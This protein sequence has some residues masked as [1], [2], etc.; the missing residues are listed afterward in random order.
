LLALSCTS[1]FM[2]LALGSIDVG[3]RPFRAGGY[4]G[5]FVAGL[6]AEYLSRMGS[7]IVI[8]ALLLVAVILTTQFSFGRLFSVIFAAV[9]ASLARGWASF[10]ASLDERRKAR[11]RRE[12]IAKH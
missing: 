7:I 4:L 3:T 2:S 12:V 6:M 11:Q 8:L 10:R 1:A 9:G 5:D